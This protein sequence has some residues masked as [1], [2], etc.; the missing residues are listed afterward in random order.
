MLDSTSQPPAEW[1]TAR[2]KSALWFS[3]ATVFCLSGIY[4]IAR[5]REFVFGGLHIAL[6]VLFLFAAMRW[7]TKM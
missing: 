5:H 4:E 6:S 2:R 3:A 1:W 7:R